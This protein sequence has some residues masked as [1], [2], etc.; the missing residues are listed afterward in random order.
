[1]R[2]AP[3]TRCRAAT[4]DD[5]DL[6]ERREKSHR[7]QAATYRNRPCLLIVYWHLFSLL[8]CCAAVGLAAKSAIS[9]PEGMVVWVDYGNQTVEDRGPLVGSGTS[10]RVNPLTRHARQLKQNS[11]RFY[12]DLEDERVLEV[13]LKVTTQDA[14]THFSVYGLKLE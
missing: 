7:R 11:V 14:K 13:S 9:A 8:G 1:M 3:W 12:A 4:H 5:N 2:D 10:I 6:Y